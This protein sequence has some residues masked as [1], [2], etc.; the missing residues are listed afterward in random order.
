M[1]NGM[2]VAAK[3]TR[4]DVN[5]HGNHPD[6]SLKIDQALTETVINGNSAASWD[7]LKDYIQKIKTAIEKDVVSGRS[8]INNLSF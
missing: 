2:M 8:D 4:L 7:N 5:G 6:Y 3:S 1:F